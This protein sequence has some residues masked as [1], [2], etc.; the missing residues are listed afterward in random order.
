LQFLSRHNLLPNQKLAQQLAR[1][2]KLTKLEIHNLLIEAKKWRA[3][4]LP[5]HPREAAS[6]VYVLKSSGI[7]KA[8]L[9]YKRPKDLEL[10]DKGVEIFWEGIG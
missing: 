6:Q 1:L 7:L 8:M 4:C 3:I 9:E 2:E 5:K 10:S